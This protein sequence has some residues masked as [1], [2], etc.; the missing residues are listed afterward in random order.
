MIQYDWVIIDGYNLLHKDDELKH[1]IHSDLQ[2]ARHQLIR[3]IENTAQAMAQHTT[4]VFDGKEAGCDEALSIGGLE[5]MFAPGHLTADS[6]IERIV[7]KAGD[8]QKIIVVTS[9]HAESD[10][11]SSAGAYTMSSEDFLQRCSAHK[12]R[13]IKTAYRKPPTL[14]D[15]FPEGL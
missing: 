8:T 13:P 11:V 14:G 7:F 3:K 10:T 5:I 9:D 4:V 1:L 15:I 12:K 2:T 6:I